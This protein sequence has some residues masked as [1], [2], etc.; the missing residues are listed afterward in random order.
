MLSS[1]TTVEVFR[2]LREDE[3]NRSCFD[4][5][6][7][8]VTHASVNLGIMLCV[9]CASTHG[10]L[11]IEISH[12]KALN[13]AWT[14]R[15]LKLMTAGGNSSLKTFL[16][17]YSIPLNAP[18]DYK[19]RTVACEYYREMLKMM[20]E[21]DRIMMVTPSEEEGVLL[22]EEF[23]TQPERVEEP[24]VEPRA[25]EKTEEEK[26]Q[27]STIKAIKGFT[28]EALGFVSQGF[29]WGAEKSKEGLEWGAEK[30]KVGL[31]WGANQG[32]KIFN[33]VS[34]KDAIIEETEK[35]YRK[36]QK[37][38]NFA[39]L[40]QETLKMLQELEEKTKSDEIIAKK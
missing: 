24:S 9:Q 8:D 15:H 30:G 4:C 10:P 23:R 29:R 17:M 20:A 21:G 40:K 36:I 38:L 5:G 26:E 14:T 25:E 33:Q 2:K 19:Y 18:N 16:A 12:I 32:K 3:D 7:I 13:E 34:N 22:M 37:N 28:S 1:R 11:G 35:V 27:R 6:N 39:N 31:E